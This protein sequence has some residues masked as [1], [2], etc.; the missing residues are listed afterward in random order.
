MRTFSKK[1]IDFLTGK[2][3]FSLNV[4]IYKV[5]PNSILNEKDYWCEVIG[6]KLK[7]IDFQVFSQGTD[8][9]GRVS[10][11]LKGRPPAPA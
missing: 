1:N 2:D 6:C 5:V 9:L 4:P 8:Y 10:D 3:G 11:F 7:K